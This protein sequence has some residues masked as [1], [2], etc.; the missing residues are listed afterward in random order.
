M[1]KY[2]SVLFVYIEKHLEYVTD[3]SLLGW[4]VGERKTC[5][6]FIDFSGRSF[7]MIYRRTISDEAGEQVLTWE[8]VPR[9]HHDGDFIVVVFND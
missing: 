9:T 2:E 4:P 5:F 3:A 6:S 1:E 7:E 8:Y